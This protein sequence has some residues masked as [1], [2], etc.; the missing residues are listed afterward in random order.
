MN[1]QIFLLSLL[2]IFLGNSENKITQNHNADHKIDHF[3]VK[4]QSNQLEITTIGLDTVNKTAPY[5]VLFSN[6]FLRYRIKKVGTA[7]NEVFFYKRSGFSNLSDI[8]FYQNNGSF[9]TKGPQK[10]GFE[11][12]TFPFK[13][14]ISDMKVYIEKNRSIKTSAET[15]HEHSHFSKPRS[16]YDNFEIEVYESGSWEITLY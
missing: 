16:K 14:K 15:I 13:C 6:E 12:V 4:D 3:K 10:V 5:K 2:S 9:T 8:K 11:N 7:K 1:T